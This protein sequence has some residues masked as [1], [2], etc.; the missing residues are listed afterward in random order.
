MTET[1][2][3]DVHRIVKSKISEIDFYNIPFGKFYSDHMFMA[4]FK[5]RE[6]SDFKIVAYENL[7]LSPA[8]STL[9]YGQS[10]FE[11]MKAHKNDKG[12]VLIFRPLANFNR[13]NKS[14]ERL[15]IPQLPE[16]VFMG[17][18]TELLKLDKNWVPD[19]PN[20]ALYI[21]PFIFATD[22][23]IGI[24]P[25]DKYQFI[26]FTCPVGAYYAEPVRVK[27]ET[28]FS[29][30]CVGGTGYAKAAGNYAAALYPARF[31]QQQGYHQLLWTDAH[32]HEFIEE[33]GT[34]NVMFLINDTLITA[35]AGGTIL[36]GVTRDCVLTLA[37]SWGYNVEERNVSVNEVIEAIK[38]GTL[39]EAFGTG[40][41]ATIAQ[42]SEIGHEDQN[43]ILPELSTRKLSIRLM[44][45]LDQIK[46][47][48]I[49]DKFGWTYKI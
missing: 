25:S 20:T 22:E 29:R 33:S 40:T 8:N 6:W 27:I 30:A 45:E 14:A 32:S 44:S 47:G 46:T 10:V 34:M 5:G 37:K 18:L 15:C 42:I 16:E 43:Y 28:K 26:I 9:H 31:A 13:L 24:R 48:K 35:P 23:Y 7:S 11:G 38:K 17:G 21:R 2:N 41:A 3:I 19:I 4:E 39:Q 12:E 49:E 36:Q 1:I